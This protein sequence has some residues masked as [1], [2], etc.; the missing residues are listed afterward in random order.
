MAVVEHGSVD[1]SLMTV[2]KMLQ[3]LIVGG[4]DA[5]SLL[6]AELIEHSLGDGSAN[7][8]LG[9]RAKL[10]YQDDGVAVGCLHHVLHIQE[11]RRVGTQ[12]VL[13]ALLITDVDHDVLEY[14]RLGTFAYRN[15]QSALQHILEQAHGLQ[16]Y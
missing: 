10:I 2:G 4:D 11:V 5:V 1:H 3:V 14:A 6:L 9:T 13:Q 16:A 12:V 8:R 15:A 7:A